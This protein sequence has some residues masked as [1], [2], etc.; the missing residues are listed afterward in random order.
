[1]TDMRRVT[2]NTEVEAYP[3]LSIQPAE[4]DQEG[5][6]VE[7]PAGMLARLAEAEHAVEQAQI[8]IMRYLAERH[9]YS[10]IRDWVAEQA[11]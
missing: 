11:S 7:I 4:L 9:E 10:D 6:L 3:V 2:I 1:M 8:E 5:R